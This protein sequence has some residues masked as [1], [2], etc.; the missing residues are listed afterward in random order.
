[1]KKADLRSAVFCCLA[2]ALATGGQARA[3]V[4]TR[5][6]PLARGLHSAV[7]DPTTNTMIVF[8]GLEQFTSGP[9][10]DLNDVW[11]LHSAGSSSL[12]WALL[13]PSGTKPAPR[14]GPTAVYD[15]AS[16]RMTIFG[17]GLGFSSPCANDVWVLTHANGK[18]GTPTWTRLTTA[19][20]APAPRKNGTAIYNSATNTMTIFG[21]DDCFS[22]DFGD[23]WVLSHANGLGGTP[24]WKMLSPSGAAPVARNGTSAV[25][26]SDTNEMV[27]FGGGSSGGL[28]NDTWVLSGANGSGTAAWTELSP[29]GTPPL[30]RVGH[31]AV[32][33][34]TN[35]RMII[36]GGTE[37][38]GSSGNSVGD[39]WVLTDA[40]SDS[41]I[42]EWEELSPGGVS[43][44]TRSSHTAV[45][46]AKANQ[47]TIFG[48]FV[49]VSGVVNAL[50]SVY[51][52][53]KAN[54]L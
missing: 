3:Q 11:L 53:S 49:A 38:V 32:Y 5:S 12:D 14:L 41:A 35:D 45:Y 48:G 43:P 16:N 2:V 52:L 31:S 9:V 23:V 27:I 24:T 15:P 36:H 17:G 22:T 50:S 42:P 47:M 30:P 46:N 10:A 29:S 39:T 19:G 7:L 13:S 18:G 4:W 40:T 44:G 26:N 25:Y 20:T 21:G 54:G 8:A 51:V 34:Q 6:G 37:G 1:M 33:D 28:L